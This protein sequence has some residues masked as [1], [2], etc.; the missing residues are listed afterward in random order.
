MHVVCGG[1]AS[2]LRLRIESLRVG[3]QDDGRNTCLVVALWA[4]DFGVASRQSEMMQRHTG[5]VLAL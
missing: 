2:I 5:M 4:M 3:F 1:E